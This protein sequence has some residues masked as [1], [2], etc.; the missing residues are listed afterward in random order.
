MGFS[1]KRKI[2][3][4]SYYV[5]LCFRNGVKIRLRVKLAWSIVVQGSL[6]TPYF[7]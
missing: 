1:W 5:K 6:E 4:T 3:L 7:I 2:V